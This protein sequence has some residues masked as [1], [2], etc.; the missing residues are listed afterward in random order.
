MCNFGSVVGTALAGDGSGCVTRHPL[1]RFRAKTSPGETSMMM[2]CVA[3]SLNMCAE[4]ELVLSMDT[5]MVGL[6][7][8]TTVYLSTG[9]IL[10]YRLD[11]DAFLAS[12]F[13]QLNSTACFED[14]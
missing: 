12:L 11:T 10:C 13:H 9:T 5:R 2:W 8:P 1:M 4:R 14:A 3:R 7:E 6:T